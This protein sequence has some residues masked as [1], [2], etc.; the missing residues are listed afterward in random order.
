MNKD[1]QVSYYVHR[2][3]NG[4]KRNFVLVNRDLA[5]HYP[6]NPKDTIN[7]C[8]A[9]AD[10][11]FSNS[12]KAENIVVI[13]FAETATAIGAIVAER[14]KELNGSNDVF[15]ITTTRE[16]V[17]GYRLDF[18]EVHSHAVD[19]SLY[20]GDNIRDNLDF[21]DRIVIIDDELSTGNTLLNLI[22]K[23]ENISRIGEFTSVEA[24][25]LL[26]GMSEKNK[27]TFKSRGIR[28]VYLDEV[29]KPGVEDY[30]SK[31]SDKIDTIDISNSYAT[32][33][34]WNSTYNV[35]IGSN[36]VR[37]G[38]NIQSYTEAIKNNLHDIVNGLNYNGYSRIDV[39]GTEECIYPSV[40]LADM[41]SEQSGL[42]VTCHSTTRS[43]IVANS[44]M[45]LLKDRMELSSVYDDKRVTYIYN[46]GCIPSNEQVLGIIITDTLY[47]EGLNKLVCELSSTNKFNSLR[48]INI[49][50]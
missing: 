31:L 27:N 15:F 50:C 43:P 6:C 16:K 23:I 12:K 36:N 32:D 35:F 8:N 48:V 7:M 40:I 47:K 46:I 25:T 14:L 28:V 5:K 33:K 39:I 3:E 38:V 20:F 2:R 26:N 44:N 30:A 18:E 9:L 4:E 37:Y 42:K 24:W 41:I 29:N 10:K 22:D 34:Q 17:I 19:Q 11:G 21:C 45:E 1:T 13:A 49:H